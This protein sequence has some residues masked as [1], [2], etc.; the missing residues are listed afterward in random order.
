[1]DFRSKSLLMDTLDW[2]HVRGE[3]LLLLVPDDQHLDRAKPLV[4]LILAEN[5]APCRL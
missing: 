3:R 5:L 1:M 2:N 4:S